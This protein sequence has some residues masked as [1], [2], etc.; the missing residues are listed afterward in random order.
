[1][2]RREAFA[3]AEEQRFP[4]VRIGA[5]KVSGSRQWREFI[6]SQP[7]RLVT[8]ALVQ[9]RALADSPPRPVGS[10]T[11]PT[12]S[13]VNSRFPTPNRY[14]HPSPPPVRQ[15]A[16]PQSGPTGRHWYAVR[17]ALEKF[18][19][20][21]PIEMLPAFDIRWDDTTLLSDDANA[22]VS[23]SG[24][25]SAVVVLRSTL[26]PASVHRSMIHELQHLRDHVLCTE[27]MW[28]GLI[29]REWLEGRA[30]DTAARLGPLDDE[31]PAAVA[32]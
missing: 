8:L 20:E 15:A 21:C 5:A 11:V 13:S 19:L 25:G 32:A 24:D 6:R 3:L 27:G 23:F 18:L 31:T 1:M 14:V 28:L 29:D 10:T 16:T 22:C 12:G 26:P 4:S 30:Y 2:T 9:L 7:S 17:R